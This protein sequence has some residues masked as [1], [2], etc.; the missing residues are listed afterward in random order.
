MVLLVFLK[1]RGKI[2]III[3]FVNVKDCEQKIM[4]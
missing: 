3:P 1:E 2:A 4:A